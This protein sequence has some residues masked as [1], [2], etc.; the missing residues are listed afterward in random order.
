M[1]PPFVLLIRIRLFRRFVVLQVVL[2]G[3]RR[4][5]V[6]EDGV[7]HVQDAQGEDDGHHVQ[8]VGDVQALNNPL[9]F[10]SILLLKV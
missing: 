10:L 9:V 6:D 3:V 4:C 7:R 5:V 8:D 1:T 2:L